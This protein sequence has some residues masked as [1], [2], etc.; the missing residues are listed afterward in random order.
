MELVPIESVESIIQCLL[1][2]IMREIVGS[3]SSLVGE[4]AG[5]EASGVCEDQK[6]KGE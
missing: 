6:K 5:K 4:K 3:H 2:F 1:A